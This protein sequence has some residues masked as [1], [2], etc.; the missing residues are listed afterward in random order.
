MQLNENE[1][2]EFFKASENT[3]IFAKKSDV[4]SMLLSGKQ[5]QQAAPVTVQRYVPAP[6]AAAPKKEADVNLS[7]EEIDVLKKMDT[8]RYNMRDVDTVNKLLSEKERQTLKQLI[9]K[10][11][12]IPFQ[13]DPKT[14]QLYSISKSVYDKYLM[15]KKPGSKEVQAPPSAPVAPVQ[16]FEQKP[17]MSIKNTMPENENI[18]YLEKNGFVVVNTEGEASALSLAL[19]ESIRRGHVLG[20]RS[21]SKKFYV[22]LRQFFDRYGTSIIKTL[23]ESG[24]S[25]VPGV[26]KD[27]GI[28]ED[29]ARAIL[30]LLAENGD[31]TEKRRDLFELA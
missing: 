28:P 30:Y 4:T 20:T 13:R 3:F 22:V 14:K 27:V 15:R 1:E 9:A 31:V 25:R 2:V 10:K 24:A 18:Q 6:Q 5:P 19:E 8:L 29:G 11:A 26:A 17:F 16:R 7:Q 21:F 23:R 12:V